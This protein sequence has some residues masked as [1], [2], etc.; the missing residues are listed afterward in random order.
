MD[1][2][3][4]TK[5]V[6]IL[7]QMRSLDS[8]LMYTKIMSNPVIEN[9]VLDFIRL[10]QLYKQGVDENDKVIGLY[11]A[12]TEHI[13]PEKKAGTPYTLLDS[14]AFYG[15][16]DIQISGMDLIIN[17]DPIKIDFK[18]KKT[19]L[20]KKY[21]EEIIGLNL[22]SKEKLKALLKVKFQDEVRRLLRDVK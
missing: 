9:I 15:S 5:L 10:D 19:D 2:F 12:Y 11:T 14:G 13:N 1:I 4:G 20:F 18:G 6:A 21:G 16:M 22:E 8:R 17:A 7:H 3:A